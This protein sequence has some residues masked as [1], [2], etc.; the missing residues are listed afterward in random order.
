MRVNYLTKLFDAHG[1]EHVYF[2]AIDHGV[3]EIVV[4]G[5]DEYEI[6]KEIAYIVPAGVS[7]EGDSYVDV[8]IWDGYIITVNFSRNLDGGALLKNEYI[9]IVEEN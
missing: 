5:G 3:V 2:R 8:E 6:A 4:I 7:F 9:K 1:V